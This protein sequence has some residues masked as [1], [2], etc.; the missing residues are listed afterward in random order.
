[1]KAW[2]YFLEITMQTLTLAE[3]KKNAREY[4]DKGL[5]TAQHPD[6]NKRLCV[7]KLDD[8]RCAVAASYDEQTVVQIF[9]VVE[10]GITS[11]HLKVKDPVELATIA[12]IQYAHDVW[13]NM[14]SRYPNSAQADDLKRSFLYLIN[15]PN[16]GLVDL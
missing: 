6:P 9:G 14:S 10:N 4:Y 5:L 1:V 16:V 2:G 15:H 12:K 13:A 3:V 7:N 8:Y 11:G